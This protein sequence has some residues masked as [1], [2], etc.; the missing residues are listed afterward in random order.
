MASDVVGVS[1]RLHSLFLL[2]IMKDVM[3]HCFRFLTQV[4]KPHNV[5]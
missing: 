2:N 3:D 1:L 4:G 5:V